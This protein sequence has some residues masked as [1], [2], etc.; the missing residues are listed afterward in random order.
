MKRS[1]LIVDD[2]STNRQILRRILCD[3]YEIYEA[4][5]GIEALEVMEHN[6][7]SLSAVLLDLSMP[8]MDGF[9][10]LK[11]M[12]SSTRLQQ[13][14]VIVTTGQTEDASEVKALKMGAS[15]YVSKPYNPAIIKQ[16]VENAINLREN[17]ATINE[18]QRDRLTGLYNRNTFFE[19]AA[20]MIAAKP[21][22]YYVMSCF[23][24]DNFKVINDQYGTAKGDTVLR[25]IAK[26]F[27][28]GFEAT[29]GLC[30]RMM[31]DNF[32]IVYPCSFMNSK[33]IEELRKKAAVL[34][35]SIQPIA[36]S[37]GR[38]IIDDLSLSVSAMYDRASLAEDSIKGLY[39]QTIIQF[40]DSMRD[41]LLLQQQIVNDMKPAL[42]RGEFE[43]W[44]QPQYNHAL[45][46]LV[47]AEALARWRHPTKGMISPGVFV[48]IFEKNG[49][50]YE[51][52]KYIWEQTCSMLHKWI[53]EGRN[54]LPVSVNISRYDAFREDL[55]DTLSNLIDKYKVPVS[56]L[57]LE[58]TESAFS[59]GTRQIIEVVKRL[60]A[61]GF[62]VEI[63]DFGSGYSSLNTLKDV[64]AQVIKLDMK[65]LESTNESQRGGSIIES[66][67]R[68]A[69]WLNMT[70]IA[71]G[72]ET[73]QQADF[74]KSIGCFLVQGYL[75]S[76]ALPQTDYEKL[77]AASEKQ[78]VTA[79]VETVDNLNNNNFW[80]PESIDTMMFNSYLGGAC[81][82]EYNSGKIELI[83]ANDKYIKVI[84]SAGMTMEDALKLN[85]SEYMDA[86]SRQALDE[87]LNEKIGAGEEK[88]FDFVF[89]NLPGCAEKTY[90]RSTMRVIAKAGPRVLIYCNNENITEQ[91]LAEQ[92]KQET[93]EQLQFLESVA[94]ELLN[95]QNTSAGIN[96]LLDRV[97]NHF[98]ADR[99]YIFEFDYH[100]QVV[101]NTYELCAPNVTAEKSRLQNV[102][103]DEIPYWLHA[104][105]KRRSVTIDSV[106]GLDED[107]QEK[108][109]LQ[110]QNI[111]SLQAMPLVQNGR[112]IGFLGIDN[113]KQH[114]SQFDSLTA[115]GDYAN[116]LINR[117][118]SNE[119]ISSEN[120]EK[121]AIMDGIPGGF[122]RMQVR[123][124]GLPVPLFFSEGL[125]NLLNMN[126]AEMAALYGNDCMAG[127]H[128]D[129]LVMV[130][131]EIARIIEQGEG[132][133][134][135]YRL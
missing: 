61:L 38:Y 99:C 1:L 91:R 34:D 102:P 50:V 132:S 89:T 103:L 65:F 70:V 3:E 30:C 130:R 2:I 100:K 6:Y 67:V 4:K 53:A 5:D 114:Q 119:E 131:R 43:A 42:E 35:G 49:F 44:F 110:A 46:H 57:R 25:F 59:T 86:A 95:Q 36:F 45:D 120:Q 123:S 117:R 33:E 72:V 48:P 128:P 52:D 84:G 19:K 93:T 76:R 98:A 73:S 13:I 81:I 40:S 133:N 15:D 118:D 85:W 8:V 78:F 58:I 127:V 116:V 63:D 21:A 60:I 126:Q 125:K 31:A 10:V 26:V 32:A 64:P 74:L 88:V 71:E 113:P 47:G 111:T 22:G 69:K 115:L 83:R 75:Y 122:V 77:A 87:L 104:F 109:L 28:E 16:R 121:L 107:R 97:L 56:L 41:D 55:I 20:E 96:M 92:K 108:E 124:D 54:P 18:L 101:N 39:D 135:R 17:A 9:A 62:I 106:D 80:N 94:H 14:P 24:I 90:L 7:Q 23:D 105:D 29:G 37:I 12:N 68:M 79:A 51:L 112:V 11:R 66:I 27:K 82:L 129:D 134:I